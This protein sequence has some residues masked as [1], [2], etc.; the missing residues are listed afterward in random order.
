MSVSVPVPFGVF[1]SAA[2]RFAGA[3]PEWSFDHDASQRLVAVAASYCD[4]GGVVLKIET[5]APDSRSSSVPMPPPS[6]ALA[7]VERSRASGVRAHD[8]RDWTRSVLD[9]RHQAVEVPLQ[10]H[11]DGE[12]FTTVALGHDGYLAGRANIGEQLV[13]VS[14]HDLEL[15]IALRMRRTPLHYEL[16]YS[17]N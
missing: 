3:A 10:I 9:A 6:I 14:G 13:T 16:E 1:E 15:P 17:L 11:L 5:R 4:E 7:M 2:P 8:H 12:L